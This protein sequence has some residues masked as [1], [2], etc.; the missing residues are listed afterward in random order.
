MEINKLR[1]TLK[2]LKDP[3]R[4]Y[5]NLRHNIDG[6]TIKHSRKSEHKAYHVV[7]ACF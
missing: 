5:G 1:E 6:K 2:S 4:Q 3:R 7:S